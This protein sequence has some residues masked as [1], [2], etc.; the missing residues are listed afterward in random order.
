MLLHLS[1]PVLFMVL[2]VVATMAFS[3]AVRADTPQTD[4]PVETLVVTSADRIHRF[5]VEVAASD[6][7]RAMGLMFRE[8]MG[9]DTGMLFVFESEDQRYFWMKNTPLPLDII[10]IGADGAIV[11]IA[12]GTTPF[13]TDTIPSGKPARFVL[14]LNAGRAAELGIKAG[15]TASSPSMT[16]D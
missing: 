13:S 7:E 10:F 14:E 1:R 3:G 8:E 11:S 5:Q 2:S 9:P 16:T 15:D 4:L 6:R 12:A